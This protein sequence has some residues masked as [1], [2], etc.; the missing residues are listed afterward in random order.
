M[1][2]P[3]SRIQ[4]SIVPQS[5]QIVGWVNIYDSQLG[6]DCRVGP[7]VEIGT[8]VIGDRTVI[9]SHSYVCPHVR[10]G[11]DCFVAH[12]VCFCNDML[13]VPEQYGSI[14]ELRAKWEPR[15]TEVGNSVRIGSGAVILPGVH[16]G[17]HCVI[18]AGAV[19]T[20]DMPDGEKWAGVPARQ[21]L[22]K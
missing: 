13:T 5:C 9:S 12:A 14:T 10:I 22:K 11:S 20:R 3:F 1:E 4:N 21:M 17:N 6:Q 2:P 8:A 18:G 15:P 16:I 19:V 7:F